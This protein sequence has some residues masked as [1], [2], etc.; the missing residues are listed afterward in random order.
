MDCKR[1]KSQ[2]YEYLDN[3]LK[4]DDLQHVTE[5]LSTCAECQKMYEEIKKNWD[6]L[7][8]LPKVEPSPN[9]MSQFWSE[10]A[11]RQSIVEK[12][13]ERSRQMFLT[14]KMVPVYVSLC[15]AISV[16]SIR[17]YVEFDQSRRIMAEMSQ[18]EIEMVE[19]IE[20]AENYELID[21]IEFFED[22]EIIQNMDEL[23][24]TQG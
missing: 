6:A 3:E 1:L 20:L 23:K 22:F 11:T 21:E 4:A 8:V 2:I 18:D 17:N 5:H 9:Y 16:F 15:I 24:V 12:I 13:S 10:V 19:Y 7:G 14:W